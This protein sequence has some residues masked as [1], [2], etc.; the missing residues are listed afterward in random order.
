M[1]YCGVSGMSE[2]NLNRLVQYAQIAAD[3]IKIIRNLEILGVP[4]IQEVTITGSYFY[5]INY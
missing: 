2:E 1:S 5:L 3:G 4:I